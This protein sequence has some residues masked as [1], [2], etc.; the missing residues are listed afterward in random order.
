MVKRQMNLESLRQLCAG[1]IVRLIIDR[2][3]I[4]EDIDILNTKM[5]SLKPLIYNTY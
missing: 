2:K 5:L 3:T 4:P 1:N